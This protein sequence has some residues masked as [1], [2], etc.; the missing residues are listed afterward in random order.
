MYKQ[1]KV[2][3]G[4]LTQNL[5]EG[6]ELVKS[7]WSTHLAERIHSMSYIIKDARSAVI[8][9]KDWIQGHHVSPNI[10]KFKKA[11][12][13]YTETDEE[14]WKFYLLTSNKILLVMLIL[15]EVF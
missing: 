7:R 15:T 14:N 1:L 10:M 5:Q 11:D 2:W 4:L 12:D 6:I 13:T 8:K 9:L 3:R